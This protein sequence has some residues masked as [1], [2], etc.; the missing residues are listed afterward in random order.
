VT[1]WKDKATTRLQAYLRTRLLWDGCSSDAT[2]GWGDT[3][4][5]P[6]PQAWATS[7]GSASDYSK[8]AGVGRVSLGSVDVPRFVAAG[9][10]IGDVEWHGTV[11]VPVVAAGA[12]IHASGLARYVDTA[13]HYGILLDFGTG[14]TV[15]VHLYRTVAGSFT[16][17]ASTTA[18]AYGAGTTVEWILQAYGHQGG[19]AL[20]AKA[21]LST[22]DEPDD[23]TL[24]GVVDNTPTLFVGGLAVRGYLGAAN[25]NT[26]PVV[27]A[28][29]DLTGYSPPQWT[30]IPTGNPSVPPAETGRVLVGPRG[31]SMTGTVGR[32]TELTSVVDPSQ[33]SLVLED[34]DGH[35]TPGNTRSPLWPDWTSG[36]PIRWTETVG[37][38]TFRPVPD[39]FLELPQNYVTFESSTD[40]ALTDRVLE[41]RCVDLLTNLNNAPAF[42]S[43]LAAHIV[44]AARPGAL[45]AYWP[46]VDATGS[47]YASSAGPVN[48]GPLRFTQIDSYTPTK[49]IDTLLNFGSQAGP[50]GD[51]GTALEFTQ[52][53]PVG[54]TSPRGRMANSAVTNCTPGDTGVATLACWVYVPE[55]VTALDQLAL[56]RDLDTSDIYILLDPFGS[57]GSS[58][59]RADFSTGT[60]IDTAV[61]G[62]PITP[63]RWHIVAGR[64]DFGTGD[65]E[66]WVD[67]L[68]PFTGNTGGSGTNGKSLDRLVLDGGEG[69]SPGLRMAHVQLYIGDTEAFTHD[70]F[71]TQYERGMFGWPNQSV[72]ERIRMIANLAGIGDG[73]LDLQPSDSLIQAPALAGRNPGAAAAAA[74]V[75]GG[76]ILFTRDSELVYQDRLHRFDL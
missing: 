58:T 56:W 20:K 13:N 37:A 51:D 67:D 3:E 6:T 14:G 7:G 49:F 43:N 70:D 71:V 32:A 53:V 61:T 55:G 24:D 59:W 36:V 19:T 30:L 4:T 27:L 57:A 66:L 42:L 65:L 72:D 5:A 26:L 8:S 68:D 76:G 2:D 52:V 44:Y 12:S 39:M 48:Q 46:L 40:D 28:F 15:D 74:S 60:G 21:W 73:Q 62:T 9:V 18:L 25:S 38:R 45:R 29:D 10:N 1:L 31:A 75:T 64:I 54:G 22:D 69:T 34:R 63:A 41:V 35:Y 17:L 50:P 11:T 16:S 47:T 23:W 33:L